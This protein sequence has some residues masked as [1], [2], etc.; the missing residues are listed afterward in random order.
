[1]VTASVVAV[2][3][4]TTAGAAP[5]RDTACAPV[6]DVA[7][8][9]ALLLLLTSPC[10]AATLPG[11]PT[12]AA[13]RAWYTTF[14]TRFNARVA[15]SF[16]ID[17]DLEAK[18]ARVWDDMVQ[19]FAGGKA[20]RPTPLDQYPLLSFVD[21]RF[22]VMRV[23]VPHGRDSFVVRTDAGTPT[24]TTTLEGYLDDVIYPSLSAIADE[25]RRKIADHPE[26][27]PRLG[28]L[29]AQNPFQHGLPIRVPEMGP[30]KNRMVVFTGTAGRLTES[31]TSDYEQQKWNAGER[32]IVGVMRDHQ[33]GVAVEFA[34]LVEAGQVICHYRAVHEVAAVKDTFVG[35]G[36]RGVLLRQP[37]LGSVVEVSGCQSACDQ[38]ASWTRIYPDAA[39]VR[40]PAGPQ[41]PLP[42][43]L[44]EPPAGPDGAP[45]VPPADAQPPVGPS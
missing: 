20:P 26:Y 27:E 8:A 21:E 41:R 5:F 25:E 7:A 35:V 6:V 39:D 13:E 4:E 16:R 12:D 1:M 23:K 14:M 15:P 45:F 34:D 19:R 9:V 17:P 31:E 33:W 22:L 44:P 40:A 18:V 28:Q 11:V 24:L 32:R 3:S 42:P 36:R 30:F 43:M 10:L 29:S 37:R 38:T 2:E